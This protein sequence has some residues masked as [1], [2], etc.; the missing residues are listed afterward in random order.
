[1][2]TSEEIYNFKKEIE[3]ILKSAVKAEGLVDVL[4]TKFNFEKSLDHDTKI[5]RSEIDKFTKD[6]L[7]VENDHIVDA[8]VKGIITFNYRTEIGKFLSQ[9]L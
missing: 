4:L 1:M 6:N 7:S 2:F 8:I 3:T 9:G 5:L